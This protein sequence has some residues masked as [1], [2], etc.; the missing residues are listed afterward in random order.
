MVIFVPAII[1]FAIIFAFIYF[2]DGIPSP[3]DRIRN[4]WALE[5]KQL[6]PSGLLQAGSTNEEILRNAD[7]RQAIAERTLLKV[8]IG[9]LN[10]MLKTR[11]T[12]LDTL[13]ESY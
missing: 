4:I 9:F 13:G 7:S 6:C 10:E 8:E 5:K 2:M 11:Q 3:V 1:L 12:K